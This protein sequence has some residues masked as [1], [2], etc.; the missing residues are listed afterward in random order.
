MDIVMEIIACRWN[1]DFQ[2]NLSLHA[3]YTKKNKEVLFLDEYGKI[4]W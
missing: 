3:P 1:Y 4:T 2:H